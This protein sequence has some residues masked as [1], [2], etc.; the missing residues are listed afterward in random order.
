MIK[1]EEIKLEKMSEE[2]DDENNKGLMAVIP[3]MYKIN[4]RKPKII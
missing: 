3:K 1:N 2:D 4:S